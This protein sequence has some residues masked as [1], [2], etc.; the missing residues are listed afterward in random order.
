MLSATAP[1]RTVVIV[2]ASVAGTRCAMGLRDAGF[3]GRVVLLE[4]DEGEP[5]DK[6]QLSKRLGDDHRLELLA[7]ESALRERAVDFR[8]GVVATGLDLAGRWVETSHGRVAFDDLVIA[9]GCRP[10]EV[11]YPLPVGAGY[12]RTRSDWVRLRDA[13]GRGGRL[14]VLGG[15]F[16]GL[17]T[18]AAAAARGMTVTVVDVAPRILTRGIPASAAARIADEHVGGGVRFRL[19]TTD[20]VLEP[21]AGVACAWGT[22]K[23]TG[24]SSRSAPSPTS[25]GWRTPG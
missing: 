23:E 2:G 25:S 21:R 8:P 5:Y 18:A 11:P 15:G 19:G 24:P 6:P 9:T 17:E 3:A 7:T 13:V 22:W 4:P 12:V 14:L 16:L 20:P 1:D 10:R